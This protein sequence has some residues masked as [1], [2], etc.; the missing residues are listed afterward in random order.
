MIELQ[1]NHAFADFRLSVGTQLPAQGISAIFGRSG[2]GKTT[3]IHAVAGALRPQQGRIVVAGT[4]FVDTAA[5]V[6]L[7]PEK[8]RVGVVF[9]DARL[10]PHYSV[11]GNLR[12][13]AARAGPLPPGQPLIEFDA[14]VQLLGIDHLLARRP[15]GLSGGERQR[16]ALG[17]ALL[18]QPRLLLMDEPLA[19]LDGARKAELLPYIAQ[20][21][22]HYRI[23][24]LYVSHALDE[25]IALADHLLLLDHGQVARSGPLLEVLADPELGPLMGRFEA[26]AVLACTVLAHDAPLHQSTLGFAGGQ[27]RVPL[28]DLPPGQALRVR[29]RARDVSLA[30]TEPQGISITNRL[31][32]V[33]TALLPR[34]APYVD[35]SVRVGAQAA[36]S[37][38]R[39]VI[40]ALVTQESVQRLGLQVGLPV[41]ALI[42]TV[43]MD[44]RSVGF[45]QRARMADNASAHGEGMRVG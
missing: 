30:L 21:R 32:G 12:Y 24:I 39:S 6:F 10:F 43:A 33:I 11:R 23:P 40:R 22:A 8:R 15:Q 38:N 34:D 16:V 3:L 44:S 27:L 13:G 9:Q 28:V 18:A 7:P 29:L 37:V 19:A 4:V 31:P 35:V 41:W 42:K 20:L 36:S 5:R 1:L 45:G 14:V 2:S 17:R 25:V 26:G